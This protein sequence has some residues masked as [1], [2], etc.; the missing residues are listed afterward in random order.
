MRHVL[1]YDLFRAMHT[2]NIAAKSTF[3]KLVENGKPKGLYVLMEELDAS[4]LKINKQ[5]TSAIIFKDP[6]IFRPIPD[7]LPS[8]NYYQQ[9]FPK[10]HKRP[11]TNFIHTFHNFLFKSSDKEFAKSIWQWMDKQT[12]LDWHLILL[13]SNNADGIMKNWFLYKQNQNS[14]LKI[15]IWDYDHSFGRDGDNE[16]NMMDRPINCKKAILFERLLTIEELNYETHLAN[17]WNDLRN[18]GVFTESYINKL[19]SNY[20][21]LIKQGIGQNQLLWPYNEKWYYDNNNY[22]QEVEII[23]KFISLR[24]KQLDKRFNYEQ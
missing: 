7:S 23:K 16:Y 21:K 2:N 24:L 1:S 17:R 13:F 15:A 11:K 19:I 3:I 9:K 20:D 14:P 4:T 5:D 18:N 10:Y 22:Q 12:T 8:N 6:P